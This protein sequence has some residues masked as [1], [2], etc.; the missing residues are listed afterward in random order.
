MN[1]SKFPSFALRFAFAGT[2]WSVTIFAAERFSDANWVSMNPSIPG[3]NGYVKAAVLDGSGNL[4]I[5]GDFTVVGD[6][7]ANHIAKW[8][9]S[10]WSALGPGI[11]GTVS[12]LAVSGSDLYAGGSFTNA[13]GTAATNIAKWD[14]SSWSALGSGVGGD[15]VRALAVSASDVYAG[16]SFTTAGGSPANC[17]A[18]WNGSSWSALG[19]GIGSTD[20]GSPY[21]SALVMLGSDLYAGGSF[22]NAGGNAANYIAK[23]DGTSWSALGSGMARTTLDPPYIHPYVNA[24]AVVGGA[25][26]A[27]GHFSMAGGGI[28]KYIAKWDGTS[29]SG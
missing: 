29:W 26:Y 20:Y 22:T 8:N 16:G 13:G 12:A 15:S 6:V 18:K 1:F 21:V 28:V 24:L 17:I 7:V 11:N 10:S 2:L 25:L 3:A 5:G 14:G 27:G 19:S 4:Y 9:G 23:W